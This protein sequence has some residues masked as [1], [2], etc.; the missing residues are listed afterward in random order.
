MLASRRSQPRH[1]PPIPNPLYIAQ[2]TLPAV[3]GKKQ[4]LASKLAEQAGTQMGDGKIP[5]KYQ[6]HI[7]VLSEEASR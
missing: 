3:K 4:T 2:V 5:A 7:Q 1:P 6:H